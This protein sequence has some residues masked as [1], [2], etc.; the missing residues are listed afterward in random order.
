M[1]KGMKHYR[2]DGA[3]HKGSFH[4]MSNGQLHS[5]KT[6]TKSSKQLFHYGDLSKKSQVKAR[7][8]WKA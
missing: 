8:S 5:G 4:K 3:E 6:H 7:K 2:K 1:G